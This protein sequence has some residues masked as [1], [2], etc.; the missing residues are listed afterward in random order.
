MKSNCKIHIKFK[1]AIVI[2]NIVASILAASLVTASF[3]I[4]AKLVVLFT[5]LMLPDSLPLLPTHHRL[6]RPK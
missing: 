3:S 6:C 5:S 2:F 4:N 1:S